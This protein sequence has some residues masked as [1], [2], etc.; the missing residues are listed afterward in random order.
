MAD[1]VAEMLRNMVLV[2]ELEPGQRLTQDELAATLGVSTMPVRE[3]LLKLAAGGLVETSPNRYFRIAQMTASDVEDNYWALATISAELARRAAERST[4]ALV[5]TL[6]RLEDEYQAA[7]AA[8]HVASIVAANHE[9]HKALNAAA[10]SPRLLFFLR[11]SLEFIPDGWYAQ[12]EGWGDIAHTAHE[13]IIDAVERGDADTAAKTWRD[14]I[15]VA[16]RQLATRFAA[17][18]AWPSA[19]LETTG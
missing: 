18:G 17:E 12:L 3:A 11:T 4:P 10:G 8:R 9:F 6:R 2:G 1:Q 7:V 15:L 16:G 19:A 5:T 14:Y 13:A